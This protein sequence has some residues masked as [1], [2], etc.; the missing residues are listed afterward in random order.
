MLSPT[1]RERRGRGLLLVLQVL[2]LCGGNVGG[3]GC[4]SVGELYELSGGAV[5]C[6]GNVGGGG[7]RSLE[8]L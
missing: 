8:E 6:G 5:S 1:R 2:M 4:W 3:G 7:C